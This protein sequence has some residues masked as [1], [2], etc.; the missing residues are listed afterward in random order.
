[1]F[2]AIHAAR[3]AKL[4]RSG[5]S[6]HLLGHCRWPVGARIPNNSAP[7]ELARISEAVVAINMALL[8]EFDPAP[9]SKA[10][11][12]WHPCAGE[13][14]AGEGLV[15]PSSGLSVLSVQSAVY[16]KRAVQPRMDTD[17][18]GFAA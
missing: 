12:D 2:I 17:G 18:H 1:M 7:T 13:G 5:I 8:T 16:P 4:R 15:V 10:N 3:S 9:T 6:S 11:R 14:Y